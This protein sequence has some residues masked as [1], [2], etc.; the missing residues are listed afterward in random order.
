MRDPATGV[1]V[2]DRAA[3]SSSTTASRRSPARRAPRTTS[4]SH[5]YGTDGPDLDRDPVQHPARPPDRDLRHGRRRSAGRAGHRGPDLRRRRSLHRGGRR[6]A[7]AVLDGR[8]ARCR[9]PMRSRTCASSSASSRR[10]SRPR[11][12]AGGARAGSTCG[13]LNARRISA[14]VVADRLGRRRRD[15]GARGGWPRSAASRARSGALRPPRFVDEAAA[16]GLD[17]AYD[18]EFRSSSAAAWPSSTATATAARTCTSAG[19]EEPAALFRNGS[20]VGGAL[21]FTPVPEPRDRPGA[22]RRRVPARHR[23]GRHRR[24]RR[25]ARRRERPAARRSATAR[26]ERA[27]EAWGFDGGHD[28]D[29]RLQRDLGGL[30]RRSADP[31]LRRLPGARRGRRPGLRL[32]RRPAR[33]GPRRWRTAV[34]AADRRC[35]QA[36]CTLVDAVQRLGPLRPPRPA[37]LERPPVLP[38]DAARSSCGAS[39][40]GA[41]AAALYRATRAGSRCSIWGMGIA[42]YDLTGDGYPEVFLTSQADNRLQTLA[43]GPS[44]AEVRGH[45][46]RARRDRARSRTPAAMDL[47]STAWHPEFADVNNDGLIDLF[48]A[49]GNVERPGRLRDAGPEQPAHRPG[50][51]DVRGGRGWTPASSSFA[52]ARGAALADLNLDG[53]LDLV[54]RQ[55]PRE[56]AAVAQRRGRQRRRPASRWATGWRSG[57]RRTARTATRSAPGSRSRVG[58]RVAAARG[59]RSA[60]ATPAAS[61][62]WIHFGLGAAD[63]AECPGH[64]AGRRGRALAAGRGRRVRRSSSAAPTRSEPWTPP[65]E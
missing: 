24:P 25:P 60:A 11:R 31:G 50:G 40:P 39:T 4:G 54:D 5:I 20:P 16:A 56:R 63:G 34:R 46:D 28:V 64:V 7:A 33:S 32:R 19:G 26:F 48:V 53:L 14:G 58:G 65:D 36:W 45:R 6:F 22:R 27:N 47:P 3:S 52:R 49:K 8:P 15:R 17:H 10:P 1:D 59:R 38:S 61:S 44:R 55:P 41:A 18:G 37:R 2:A 42:S 57:S 30:G 9:R 43:D 35:R 62:G 51:R 23:R 29:D 12:G 21:A 13:A